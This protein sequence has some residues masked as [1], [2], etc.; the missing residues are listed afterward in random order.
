MQEGERRR[1]PTASSGPIRPG[2]GLVGPVCVVCHFSFFTRK[3][4]PT[5]DHRG[6]HRHHQDDRHEAEYQD[7][8][9]GFGRHPRPRH[10]PVG[11]RGQRCWTFSEAAPETG[12]DAQPRS[13][14][15]RCVGDG[16]HSRCTWPGSSR[17]VVARPTGRN[18]ERAG[19][20]SRRRTGDPSPGPHPRP[21]DARDRSG[22]G[23]RV[24]RLSHGAE[25]G[26][27]LH[28]G[29]RL[30]CRPVRIHDGQHL[31]RPLLRGLLANE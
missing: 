22:V 3:I 16:G 9:H 2:S 26:L 30:G 25:H 10:R 8:E 29:R 23:R 5:S 14:F 6:D 7:V 27:E 21:L 1:S 11:P 31:P 28:P 13:P 24:R 4:A 19:G 18:G 15:C 20:P 17:V 12:R